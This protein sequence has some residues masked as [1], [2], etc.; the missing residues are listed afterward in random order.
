MGQKE[1]TVKIVVVGGGVAGLSCA[2]R[3]LE[4]G[5]A[6]DVWARELSPH[7]TSDVAAA[8]W[9]PYRAG[10]Q[11]L[12]IPWAMASY[13]EFTRLAGN[14]ASGVRL[15]RGVEL[16]TGAPEPVEWRAHLDAYRPAASD[17]LPPGYASGHVSRVPV[18]EMPLYLPF[19]AGRVAELGGRI[20]E[21]AAGSPD[22]A[23]AEA[24]VA[25]NCAGLGAREL[26]GDPELTPVRGQVVSVERRGV[27]RFLFDEAGESVTYVVPRSRDCILGGS[28]EEGREDTEPDPETTA[29]ILRR[30]T[31]LEPGLRGAPLL[32]VSVGLRPCRPTVRLE[33]ERAGEKLLVHDYGHGGAGVTMS[34]GCAD[35]VARL[36]TRFHTGGTGIRSKSA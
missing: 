29:A 3:L 22:D 5:H 26:V 23:L 8:V 14:P 12:A 25:V 9:Y 11:E 31:E 24:D 20:E 17:D 13:A 19:L 35:E 7:T 2:A 34:W 4:A 30:C 33:A 36:V 1:T 16:F 6:V 10:P 21:R 27:E 18:V 15:R 28:V 32:G